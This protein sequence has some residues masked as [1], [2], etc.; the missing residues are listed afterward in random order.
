[1]QRATLAVAL[2]LLG[3]LFVPSSTSNHTQTMP[4]GRTVAFTQVSGNEWWVQVRLGGSA[5]ALASSV[6]SMDTGGDWVTLTSQSWTSDHTW[7]GGSYHLEP[8]HQVRFRASFPGGP[9]NFE[10]CWF[11]F[12]QGTEQCA[13]PPPPP[14]PP[15]SGG[16]TALVAVTSEPPGAN[17]AHG[18]VRVDSGLDDGTP[19]GTAGNGV[20]EPGEVT[21][22]SYVCN[23][24]PGPTGSAGAT[25]PTGAAGPA[26]ATGPEGPTGAPGAQGPT[27]PM[28]PAGPTGPEG[29]TGPQGPTGA[30]GPQGPTGT[31]GPEGPMGP[32]GP[33]GPEGPMGLQGPQGPTGATG[34]QGATGPTGPQGATGPAGPQG[35]TGATGPQGPT[36]ATG[37][38]GSTGATGATTIGGSNGASVPNTAGSDNFYQPFVGGSSTTESLQQMPAP[39]SGTLKNLF[40]KLDVAP[41]TG[42]SRTWTAELRKNGA[43]TGILCTVTGTAT[44]CNDVTHTVPIVA[45]DLLDLRITS[46]GSATPTAFT[47]MGWSAQY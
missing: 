24:P 31:M 30:T 38:Q 47:H 22:T 35:T 11:A 44:A 39:S 8:G 26:G 18:G 9:S 15:P 20:L 42:S 23:G 17:C 4:D 41:G 27:G 19:S 45:G 28:G 43:N 2:L 12:P 1:M 32:Q 16:A 46:T 29:P 14:P 25:G 33:Q 10:S 36:G 7:W 37:P 40:V 13:A 34:P 3:A 6:Q 5:G 21:S